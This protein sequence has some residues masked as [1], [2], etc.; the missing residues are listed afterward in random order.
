MS[1]AKLWNMVRCH[2]D[3]NTESN[4]LGKVFGLLQEFMISSS[5]HRSSG[6]FFVNFSKFF[7]DIFATESNVTSQMCSFSVRSVL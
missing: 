6:K 2:F 1:F 5:L 4:Y 3:R 7:I